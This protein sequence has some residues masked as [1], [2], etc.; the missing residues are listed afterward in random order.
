MLVRI[1]RDYEEMSAQAA[2]VVIGAI[3]E[4]PDCVIT[5]P[6]GRT[7]VGMYQILIRECS[8]GRLDFSRVRLV[9]IDTVAKEPILAP[10]SH[11]MRLKRMLVGNINVAEGAWLYMD[12]MPADV[13]AYC[14]AFEDAIL[15]LGGQDLAI[16]GLGADG[17]IGMDLPGSPFES[18]TRLVTLPDGRQGLTLGIATILEAKKV[19][20]VAATSEKAAIVKRVI[21]DPVTT[22]VPATALRNHPDALMIIDE[23]A[24][25]DL[26]PAARKRIMARNQI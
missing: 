19:L 14:R 4:K 20:L 17:H 6:A 12:T 22:D 1:A 8:E 15:R 24:A 25:A 3:R 5:V 21:E 9:D 18:R 11:Y 26:S 23:E 7:P 16:A 13:G 2:E 10:Q